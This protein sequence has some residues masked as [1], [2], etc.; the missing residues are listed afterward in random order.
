MAITVSPRPTVHPFFSEPEETGSPLETTHAAAAASDATAYVGAAVAAWSSPAPASTISA[1]AQ[2][3]VVGVGSGVGT[4]AVSYDVAKVSTA[5]ISKLKSSASLTERAMGQALERAKANWADYGNTG[6]TLLMTSS[7][8]N[9]G[10]PV[11]VMI[12]QGFDK[13]KP[14]AV[15][16][17]YHGYACTISE[18]VAD[19]GRAQMRIRELQKAN[20]QLVFVLPECRNPPSGTAEETPSFIADWSNVSSQ[21]QTTADALGAAKISKV[22]LRVVSAH[23]GGHAALD[24]I[25]IA[26][27]DGSQLACDRLELLDCLYGQTGQ[28]LAAF[29]ATANGK[30]VSQ[31]R[32]VFATNDRSRARPIATAFGSRYLERDVQ[33]AGTSQDVM[34][35]KEDGT[36]YRDRAG[37]PLHRF[38]TMHPAGFHSRARGEFWHHVSRD[39]P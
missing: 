22:D 27:P 6:A 32:T 14:A 13:T 36:P 17:H 35:L 2:A 9:G 5:T 29:A 37:V 39:A 31:V 8:G 24:A 19:S 28:R 11:A 34:A 4:G 10:Y 26:H 21:V 33:H 1:L 15:H 7:P 18:S 30:R 23:S 3:A 20:P 25:L 12:P 38:I 16:T